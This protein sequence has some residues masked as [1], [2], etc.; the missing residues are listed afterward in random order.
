M[1]QSKECDEFLARDLRVT[2]NLAHETGPDHFTSVNGDHG[3]PPIQMLQEVV[4]ALDPRHL[5]ASL[6][7][8][9]NDFGSGWAWKAAHAAMVT[10]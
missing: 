9:A 5:E 7:Q 8:G 2:E 10:R 1:W 4:A 3:G 6:A